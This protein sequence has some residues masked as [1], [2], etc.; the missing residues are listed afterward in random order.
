MDKQIANAVKKF[1]E[2]KK[3]ETK[4]KKRSTEKNHSTDYK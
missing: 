2:K 3:I 1:L 4:K